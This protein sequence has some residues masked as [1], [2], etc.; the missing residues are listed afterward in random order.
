MI[1]DDGTVSELMIDPAGEFGAT[2]AE[3]ILEKL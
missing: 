1:V 2:S 3:S